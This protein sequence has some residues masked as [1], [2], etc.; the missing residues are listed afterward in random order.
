MISAKNISFKI[1]PR[2]ILD[3]V[4]AHIPSGKITAI[5]G[6]NGAGKSTLLKCLAG[7]LNTHDGAISMNG[8]PLNAYTISELSRTRAVLSQSIPVSFPF[9]VE[10]IVQ[11]GRA[12]YDEEEHLTTNSN[13]T[14]QALN[15]VDGLHLMNRVFPSLSGGEQQRI[16]FA[17]VLAQI[18]GAS[19]TYLFLDEPTSALD[20][21]HQHQMLSLVKKLASENQIGV[22]IVMHDL[23]L[24]MRYADQA[25]LVHNSKLFASGN[26]ETVLSRNNIETVFEVSASLVFD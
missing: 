11:M 10:E 25:L 22:C 15:C 24:A 18:W 23:H 2:L 13:V 4:S 16:Q 8:K 6:P 5:L 26:V 14:Y 20:L 3:Q 1:G 21:K 19:N 17:R 9:T 12:P 7:S